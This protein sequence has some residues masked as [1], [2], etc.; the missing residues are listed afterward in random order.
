MAK[1]IHIKCHSGHS[2]HTVTQV[3]AIQEV[4][5]AGGVSRRRVAMAMTAFPL[6]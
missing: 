3:L 2:G 5:L 1:I 4:R 6:L